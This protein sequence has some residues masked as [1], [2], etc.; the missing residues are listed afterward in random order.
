LL[1]GASAGQHFARCAEIAN[2]V[3]IGRLEVPDGLEQLGAAARW[4][5]DDLAQGG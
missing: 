5:E 4:I 2:G 3:S 1:N